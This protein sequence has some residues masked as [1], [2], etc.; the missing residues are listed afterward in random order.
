MDSPIRRATRIPKIDPTRD[1]IYTKEHPEYKIMLC[2][3]RNRSYRDL[4]ELKKS[5]QNV[6][7]FQE[8]R[9][10]NNEEGF[11]DLLRHCYYE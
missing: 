8:F 7:F 1:H 6:Q 10:D 11:I 4:K 9:R 2:P 3:P 5:I